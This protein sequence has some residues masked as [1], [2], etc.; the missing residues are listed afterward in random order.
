M[1]AAYEQAARSAARRQRGWA[2]MAAAI[3]LVLATTAPFDADAEARV[4]GSGPV[5]PPDSA[6]AEAESPA[7]LIADEITYDTTTGIV[8]AR[9]KVQ[10][11]H[12]GRT[13]TADEIT[14]DSRN[15]TISAMGAITLRT[16]QGETV[17]ADATELDTS[18]RN[19][20]VTGARGVI[21]GNGK[22]AAL[23]ARRVDGRY[24]ILDKA[25]F[26][27]CEVCT[28]R[29]VPLWRIRAEW[30]I[31]DQQERQIH[32][33][34]AYLDVFGVPIAFLPYFRHPSPEVERASGFLPPEIGR[35]R[36]YGPY[37]KAPYYQ[38]IDEFSDVTLTPFVS[39]EDGFV[40]ETEYRRRYENGTVDLTLYSGFTDYGDDGRDARVRIGGFGSALF[41]VDEGVTAGFDVAFAAD[42]PFL[43]RYDYTD[44]DRLYSDAFIRAYDGASYAT[45]G[46]GAIQ[47]LRNGE[48][49][50]RIP[51]VLPEF[52]LRHVTATPQIGGEL[53]LSMDGTALVREDGRDIARLSLGA[54][55]SRQEILTSGLILRGFAEARADLYQINDDAAF[56]DEAYRLA[57]RAGI[58]A[59][60]PFV[61]ADAGGMTHV[62]EPIAQFVVAP[63]LRDGDIPNE[64]SV[65]VEFDEMNLFETDR[66]TGFDRFE[67]GAYATLGAR[68]ELI[69]PGGLGLRASGG[70]VFRFADNTDFSPQSGLSDDV[71]DYVT[72]V[73]L[74]YDDWFEFGTRFR[75][76]DE[77]SANRA[78]I[79]GRLDYDPV[80]LFGYYLFVAADPAE[81]ALINRSEI[82]LGAALALDRNWTVSGDVSNDLIAERFVTAGGVLS[83]EDECAGLD[84]YVRRQF[85]ESFS[86]P[87]GTTFGFRV[88]LFGAG[89]GSAD[90]ASGACA[91]GAQ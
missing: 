36:S 29:P 41:T 74:S 31:H 76:S 8:R 66:F 12:Q 35:S 62:I 23:E 38:V 14:Y 58:E 20:I 13:L 2:T 43:R 33:E 45:G 82:S 63:D 68:Y 22:I 78:E 27:P 69:N 32:Y 39:V 88:R 30:I 91:Y 6:V 17:Y 83:Y 73:T 72:A 61:R 10:V 67:T 7:A 70:R 18:L 3:C 89:T 49:Q 64:D 16:E 40:L 87:E 9:G 37:F 85:T 47:S 34:D 19:G 65:L 24:N 1:K 25:V 52:S 15:D 90:K 81:G 28:D 26:S 71:S 42:D 86:A 60:M 44:Q 54:D 84:L 5:I 75:L 56:D 57:P 80:S 11:F 48:A 77:F 53:G 46:V 59:R 79:G 55:W 4:T 51:F 21:E 50:G